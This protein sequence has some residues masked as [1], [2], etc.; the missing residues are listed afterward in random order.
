MTSDEWAACGTV[1][2][3]APACLTTGSA[4][5]LLRG[6]CMALDPPCDLTAVFPLLAYQAIGGAPGC[7]DDPETGILSDSSG[8][9][10]V[11]Y[12]VSN[13][14]NPNS[15]LCVKALATDTVKICY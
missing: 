9:P 13:P 12:Q 3:T 14:W 1:F 6:F 4:N 5:D 2:Q 7:Y 10:L 8:K 15:V 11:F